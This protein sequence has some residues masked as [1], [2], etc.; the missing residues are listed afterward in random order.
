MEKEHEGRREREWR[1]DRQRPPFLS[2]LTSSFSPPPSIIFP[3]LIP[4]TYL[5]R[6]SGDQDV[7]VVRSESDGV[8][9]SLVSLDASGRLGRAGRVAASVPP[10]WERTKW[11]REKGESEKWSR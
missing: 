2:S 10:R 11:D 8:D 7:L 3:T 5:I 4:L 1:E 6:T 9:L